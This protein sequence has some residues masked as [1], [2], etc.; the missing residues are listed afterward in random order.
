MKAN[1]YFFKQAEFFLLYKKSNTMKTIKLILFFALIVINETLYSQTVIVTDDP[2]YT[3]G[4]ASSVLDVKSTTK[5]LLVPRMLQSERI[6]IS[7]PA[8]GLLVYQTDGTS[9]FYYFNGTI[10][11][12]IAGG[13]ISN[14]LPLTGGTMTGKFITVPSTTTNAGINIPHGVSPTTPANGDVWTTSAGIYV[15]INGS[16]IGPLTN[17]SSSAFVQNGNSFN[18]LASLGT[19]DNFDLAIK[20]NNTELMRVAASGSVGIGTSTFTGSNPEKLKVDA[21]VTGNSNYQNVLVGVGNTN[22]YAQLNINNKNSGSSASSDLI[23]TADNG[24]NSS[25]YVDMGINSSTYNVGSFNVSGPNDGYLY[26]LGSS[27]GSASGGNMLIGTANSTKAIKFFTGGTLLANEGMRIDGNGGVGIG[28]ATGASSSASGIKLN[29]LQSYATGTNYGI[30]SDVSGAGTTNYGLFSKGYNG[31]AANYGL[32]GE[33]S[34]TSLINYGVYSTATGGTTNN[35]SFWGNA[36]TFYNLGNAGIGASTFNSTNPEKL[37]VDA[38]AT[39]N[40]NY[41]NVIVGFGNTDSYAQINIKNQN[42]G[43]SASSDIVAT[44]D[45]GDDSNY[46]IDMGINS[47]TYSPLS[48]SVSGPNDGYLYVVG[49][50]DGSASG[51]NL[52]LGTANLTKSVKFFTGGTDSINERMR[53]NGNGQVK[54]SDLGNGIS[55]YPSSLLEL[56]S[57]TKGLLIPR[58]AINDLNLP[59]PLSTP[60]EGML[61]YNMNGGGGPNGFYY[62]TGSVWNLL[63]NS[64]VFPVPVSAG[65]TGLTT[66]GGT[67]TLLYTSSANTITNVPTSSADGQ[68]LHTITAGDPPTWQTVL[69]IANGGTGSATQNFVDLTTDQTV[70]GIKT[71]SAADTFQAGFTSTGGTINLNNG[72]NFV[73]NINTGTSTGLVTIGNTTG[74]TSTTINAGTGGIILNTASATNTTTT[75]G[76]TGSAVF[77]SST[78]GSDLISILPQSTAVAASNTGTITTAD[79]TAARTWALPDASGTIALSTGVNASWLMGGNAPGAPSIMGTTD[80]SS[81]TLQTGTGALNLGTDAA[82]KTITL[83]NATGV[84]SAT[85]TSGTGGINLNTGAAANETTTLGT[86][87]S[88]VFGSSTTNSD[89]IAIL[90][91]ST[92]NTTSFTGTITSVDLTAARTWTLPDVSGILLTNANSTGWLFGGNAPGAPSVFGTTDNS[93]VTVQTGTGALNLGTDA[94]AKTITLGNATG[95]TTT[96]IYSGTGGINLNT[97]AATNE[98]TTLGTTGSAVFASSTANSDKIAI[99]PQSTIN[100]ATFTGAFTSADLTAARTW[101]LPDV[102]GTLLTT[103]SFSGWLLGGNTPGGPS[104]MGTTDNSAVTLQTGTGALNL[105]TDAA[106]KAITLGNATGATSTTITSGTGGINLNT[107]AATNETTTLGTT[108]SAIFASS[109]ANSDKIAILPQSTINTATFTGAITSA[110]LTAARTWT[111]PDA[112]GTLLT[113]ATSTGWLLVGNSPGG[114]SVIGTT[115]NSSVTLQTGTGALNLGTDAAAKAITIG[116]VTGATSLTENVGTGGYTLNGVGTTN[117]AIGASTTTGTITIG[118][119]GAQTGTIGI[120]TGAGAQTMNIGTGAGIKTMNIGTG[121]VANVITIGSN[122]GAASLTEKVGTGN[123]TLNGVGASNYSIGASTTTGAITIGGTGA[124]TGTIGIGTGTGVQTINFGTGTGSQTINLGTGAVANVITM[125]SNTGAASTTINSGTGGLIFSTGNAANETT[126]LGTT[127][128]AVFASSTALSDKIAI[129]PQSATVIGTFTGTIT[130][131]DLTAA[132]TWTLPNATGTLALS[133]GAN[134]AWQL[135]G[136]APGGASIIGTTDNSAV[137]FQTGTGALNLGTDAFAKAITIGNVTGATSLTARVGTGNYTLNG[138]GVSTYTIGAATTTGTITIGGTAQTG[139][140]TLGSSSG[141]NNLFI[142]NG[143]GATTLNLANIQGGGSINMGNAMTTGTISI[144]GTGAQT[145]AIGIG[146]GTGAQTINFGTG[147]GI[148]T[149]N[150]GTGAVANVITMGSNTG[151]ASTTIKAGTGGLI[152]ST[153]AATNQTTTLGTTGAAV[154]ASS[155]ALSD[156]IA[157]LPQSTINTA[158]FTGAVTTA[159]LTAA[160]TWTFPDA[161][162]TI[163]TSGSFAGWLI[164]GNAPGGASII[165]TTDNSAVTFQTG[166]GAL[167]L[168]TDAAAK[169]ITIG[170]VTGA[171]SITENVGTGNYTLNGVGASTYTIGAATT[172]GAI[173]IGGTAQTGG[174]GIGT[175]TG[176][177]TMNIG[178]GAGIKTM[179]IGTGAVANVITIGSNTGAASLTENVGTGNYSLNGVGASNYSIGAATTSGTITIGGTGAQTG[180]IGIGTGTGAQT[181]NFGTGAGIKTMNIGT[182]AVANV[183]SIGSNTGA[184]SITINAGTGGLTFNTGA[185]TNATT[186]LGSTGSAVFASSTALSDKIAILPQ[187]TIN[188]NSFAGTITSADLTATRTWTLPDATGTLALSTGATAAWQ[189]GGNAPG[190]ASIIGTTDNS[191]VTFQ[192]GTGALNLGTDAA[193]KAITMGNVTGATSITENVGTGNY[194]LNG[195]ATSNYT[196]GAATTTGAITIGGTAQTGNMTLGSSTGINNLFIANGSGATTLNIANVQNGGAINLGAGMT[197]GTITIGG[198]GAQTGAIGIGT[199]T[200][201]QNLNFGT[202]AGIKTINIGTGAVANVVTI[203]SNTGAASTTIKAGTGYVTVVGKI[204]TVQSGAALTVSESG[205]GVPLLTANSNDVAGIIT[206][207]L[208]SHTTVTIT[209]PDT[210]TN[211][212]YAVVVPGNAAAATIAS[213]A[214]GVYVTTTPTTLVIHMA[215]STSSS[216]WVYHIFGN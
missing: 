166:T 100:T 25:Y 90:P 39:G 151:A 201:A 107:A 203:G 15:Q 163:L 92:I 66:I 164:G 27:D 71:F 109:T 152:F 141:I 156:K 186:T 96:T 105:G 124:Q 63:G 53:I 85:I 165:G 134:A 176:A 129:R 190:G 136:N 72:S 191:A 86:T 4:Q 81:I 52:D 84:T 47:S 113:T 182:G 19:N 193:A 128:S 80:N 73:T 69:G 202:G 2:T 10:W 74:A 112:G 168:G 24:D 32:Y 192:T 36:G 131:S 49:N 125:G 171:T 154:F 45:N 35:Y 44:A 169:A 210:Y 16:T 26:V 120:G 98:T 5:G 23:A 67:N 147:A 65:G 143:T 144:G 6:A 119:T 68:F 135:G 132:R 37:K 88:A 195:V 180:A 149:M 43:T 175:G 38:G 183:V 138:V 58:V 148:K 82:A 106:A 155:T 94:A 205:A 108:G 51:G 140:M 7:S 160:R 29:V 28:T 12:I 179:N 8:N 189:L 75:L 126:T 153:G 89:R 62:W 137:T 21:G 121:A 214:P 123:Y 118:G 174:I 95:A 185:A 142:A 14:Y 83:G 161:S 61:V 116:N 31:T 212:P 167:N 87:G 178:T 111:L 54:I 188:T 76:T 48:F 97:A 18:A 181:L 159:D 9:G 1:E 130:S 64:F 3:V 207:S 198:T 170:N 209:F 91:Q 79:L 145:G 99:L 115:D 101:T 187:S 46:Y 78:A 117:Y 17:A 173:T 50:A 197:T 13:T 57:T 177:Q 200:G 215:A 172:T 102:S 122:T 216:A 184:A 162:G 199:G 41:Q 196:I 70:A 114:A 56:E 158:S 211:A 139:N 33:G 150:L 127:G 157:I 104:I 40:T 93:D 20:T 55:N 103:G 194:T 59:A 133:T 213:S 146:T 30:K 204:K 11:V 60:S 22:S 208:T 77:A 42:P 206:S 34:G 110:D